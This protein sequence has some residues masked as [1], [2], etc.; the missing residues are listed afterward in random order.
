MFDE[1]RFPENIDYGLTGGPEYSTDVI[2]LFSGFEQRNQNWALGRSRYTTS[3][4]IKDAADIA[5]LIAFF[6][7][8]KGKARGFRFRD[9]SDYIAINQPIGTGDNTATIF[10]LTKSYTSGSVTEIRTCIKIVASGAQV[11]TVPKIYLSSILKTETV[12]YTLDYTT[13]LVTFASAPGTGVAITADFEFD[14][15]VRFDT[16][17]MQIRHEYGHEFY[18]ENIALIE[19]KL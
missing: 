14:V 16:D 2:E 5:T 10:Q 18:W 11:T 1:V 15:P 8:R 19:L 4:P 17:T 7:A 6:R 13:G 9:W 12:D 3:H